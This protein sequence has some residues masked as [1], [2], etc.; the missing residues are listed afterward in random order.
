MPLFGRSKDDHAAAPTPAPGPE[1]L[2]SPP[3]VAESGI[4]TVEDHRDYLLSHISSLKPFGIGLLDAWGLTL[5]ETIV[6]DLDLPTFTSA[7]VAGWAVR[8]SNLVGA[9]DSAPVSL[10]VVDTIE[11]NGFRGAPLT[12]GT[13]VRVE[14]GA[15]IP[16]GADAVVPFDDGTELSDDVVEFRTEVG[17]RQNLLTAGSRVSDGETLLD[18]GTVLD[19]RSIGLLAEVGLDKVLAR[20]R[21][22]VALVTIGSDLVPAGAPLTR[23]TQT[24]DAVTPLIAA[25]TRSDGAQ[26]FPA[27][28]I[29][30]DATAIRRTLTDQLLRADLVLVL[31]EPTQTLSDVLG[32]LGPTDVGEVAM[33]PGSTQIFGLIGEDRTP[34]IVLPAEPGLAYLTYQ[35]FG[36]PLVR[37]LAGVDPLYR[38]E[39][40]RPTTVELQQDPQRMRFLLAT[41]GSRGVTPLPAAEG[42]GAVEL[43]RANVIVVV[44]VGTET[45]PAHAD[46]TCWILDQ[47]PR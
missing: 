9:S 6:A 19:V 37:K 47:Q 11:R 22:R 43:A 36:R 15:P 8:G 28:I 7:T 10:P 16:D 42:R 29:A 2:P 32:H 1:R 24:Y 14:A 27:G 46:V 25:A 26:V 20:P 12:P 17:F 40:A 34:A 21:P 35:A 30:D 18:A 5:C 39:A 33:T 45:I 4:R 13:A 3:L 38:P 41:D 44:P 31:A 23:L